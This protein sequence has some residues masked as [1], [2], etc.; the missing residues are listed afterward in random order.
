MQIGITE[1]LKTF[2]AAAV[3]TVVGGIK[4]ASE[5]ASAL[6]TTH[7]KWVQAI[8]T[9]MGINEFETLAMQ[10]PWASWARTPIALAMVASGSH[11]AS[12]AFDSINTAGD[13]SGDIQLASASCDI[14]P[15][16][17]QADASITTES[18]VLACLT[19]EHVDAPRDDA[20]FV[21][22]LFACISDASIAAKCED[23]DSDLNFDVNL[24][25]RDARTLVANAGPTHA[26]CP[27]SRADEAAIRNVTFR[28]VIVCTASTSDG[29]AQVRPPMPPSRPRFQG[30]IRHDVLMPGR[31]VRVRS[32]SGFTV[33]V[34]AREDLST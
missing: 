26:W 31:P 18:P 22:E 17:S 25:F 10:T 1:I 30:M 7:G 19:L 21:A 33:D 28:K 14:A 5:A 24:E 4:V 9:H 27:E 12:P 34:S 13:V 20:E 8:A 32:S 3:I 6:S 2:A 29:F 23:L 15:A 11:T 16:S